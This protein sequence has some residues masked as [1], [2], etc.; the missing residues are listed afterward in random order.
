MQAS[1]KNS[2]SRT[3]PIIDLNSSLDRRLLAY[4][5]VG[6]A[7]LAA[8]VST[9]EATIVYTAAH[10]V[11]RLDVKLPIDLNHDGIPDFTFYLCNCPTHVTSLVVLGRQGNGILST[12]NGSLAAGLYGGSVKLGGKFQGVKTAG[13]MAFIG[14]MASRVTSTFASSVVRGPWA[15]VTNRYLG[16]RFILGG[17]AHYGWARLN[18]NMRTLSVLLTGYAYETEANVGIK[19]GHMRG[20]AKISEAVAAESLVPTKQPVLLGLLARGVDGLA[21]WRREEEVGAQ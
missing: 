6:T 7:G 13:S 1:R 11:V 15:N 8:S 16:L 2:S 21:I 17:Q 4:V 18:V 10:S 9:A 14:G 12:K 3:R 19:E 20:P 5:A